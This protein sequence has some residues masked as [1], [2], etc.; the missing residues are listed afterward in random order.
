M[1][2][3]RPRD[4]GAVPTEMQIDLTGKIAIVTGAG[5][6][7]GRCIASTFAEEGVRVVAADKEPGGLK[8]FQAEL[9]AQG[10]EGAVFEC[11][12]RS[13]E[14]VAALVE[15]A[16][17]RIRGN[18]HPGEQRGRQ[19]HRSGG[20][21]VAGGLGGQH[22]RQPHGHIPDLPR[23]SAGDE[24]AALRQDFECGLLRGHRA[25]HRQRRLRRVEG[26]SSSASHACSLG[27]SAPGISRST[28]T[29]PAWCR[30]R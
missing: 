26:R 23:G 13:P 18:R 19:C 27:S 10:R 14:Q 2:R 28:P 5:R 17:A 8:T 21:P 9:D 12:V 15:F 22:R 1:G 25:R 11:D 24:A 7:I 30:R 20:C 4:G 3:A 29:L 16:V 6:G